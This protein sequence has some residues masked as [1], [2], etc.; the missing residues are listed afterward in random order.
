MSDENG[1]VDIGGVGRAMRS[2]V[3]WVV[4][5]VVAWVVAG[6]WSDFVRAEKAVSAA[7]QGSGTSSVTTTSTAAGVETTVTDL[8]ATTRVD[9]VL[10]SQPSTSTAAVATSK[11]GSALE[12]LARQGAWFKVKDEAGH[13]GW[14]PNDVQYIAVKTK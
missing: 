6:F 13:V 9:V 14:I 11:K 2:M 7:E 8:V 3:P 12:V 4:L 1:S 10:R 5:I